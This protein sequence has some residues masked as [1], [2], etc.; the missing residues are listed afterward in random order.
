MHLMEKICIIFEINM[1]IYNG[2]K[3]ITKYK[4][5]IFHTNIFKFDQVL[6]RFPLYNS[7]CIVLIIFILFF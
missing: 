7:K 6:Q 5:S 3:N 2:N 1:Y 4:Y